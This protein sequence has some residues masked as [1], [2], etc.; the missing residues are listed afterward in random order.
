SLAPVRREIRRGV[1]EDFADGAAVTAGEVR[2][3]L[4]L[5]LARQH[6]PEPLVDIGLHL[7]RQGAEG[8]GGNQV[9]A[10]ILEQARLEVELA[11]A[12]AAAVEGAALR[13]LRG[14]GRCSPQLAAKLRLL[15]EEHVSHERLAGA[16]DPAQRALGVAR[17]AAVEGL[18]QLGLVEERLPR[19]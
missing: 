12:A 17:L 1:A 13:E 7:R 18:V 16:L 14:E 8:L 15:A 3:F 19:E 2:E 5:V 9:A 11:Q 4:R 10:R 6:L